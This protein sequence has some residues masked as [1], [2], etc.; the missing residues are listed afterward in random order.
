[1]IPPIRT[2]CIFNDIANSLCLLI[3]V[4]RSLTSDYRFCAP[5]EV[6]NEQGVRVVATYIDS[7]PAQMHLPFRGLA[8]DALKAA[9]WGRSISSAPHSCCAPL[10]QVSICSAGIEHE[11]ERIIFPVTWLS[12]KQ[13]RRSCSGR[14]GHL[15]VA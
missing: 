3:W 7:H 2:A 15:I 12:V 1:V 6:S 11:A 5:P 13:M 9:W 14:Q 10:P 4:G 8:L